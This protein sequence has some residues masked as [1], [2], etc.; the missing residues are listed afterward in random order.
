M[1]KEL[2]QQAS[3]QAIGVLLYV[4]LVALFMKNA[5]S[6]FGPMERSVFGPILF[7]M[8]FVVS[9]AITGLLVLGRAAYLFFSGN[10]KDAVLLII[11]TVAA[12]VV[13]TFILMLIV[14]VVS[15]SFA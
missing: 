12:L 9:A 4:S 1:K 13:L 15:L 8:L 6:I 10:K 11:S 5:N 2:I 7:L 14:A 3:L